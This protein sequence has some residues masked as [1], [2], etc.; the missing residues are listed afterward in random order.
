MSKVM[1]WVN[2]LPEVAA[3]DFLNRRNEIVELLDEAA[4]LMRKADELRAKAYFAGCSLE[5]AAKG[6]WSED[7]I[8]QAKARAG[9]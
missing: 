9:W 4:E 8:A 7:E 5:G 6:R 3:T 1:S 2:E